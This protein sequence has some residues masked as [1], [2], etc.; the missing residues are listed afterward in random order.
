LT[1]KLPSIMMLLIIRAHIMIT[2]TIDDIIRIMIVII[3][4]WYICYC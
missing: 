1:S 2:I 4:Y 3:V